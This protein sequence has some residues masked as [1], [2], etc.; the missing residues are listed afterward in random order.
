MVPMEQADPR[1]ADLELRMRAQ[2]NLMAS[3]SAQVLQELKHQGESLETLTRLAEAA[4]DA[5]TETHTAVVGMQGKVDRSCQR[6]DV[7]EN[8]KVES[9]VTDAVIAVVVAILGYLGIRLGGQP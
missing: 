3:F 9:R 7:I 1:V 4:R 6:L 8:T 2:E 5:R